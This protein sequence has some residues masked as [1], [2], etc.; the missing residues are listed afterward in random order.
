MTTQIV[1]WLNA[2]ANA[3][4]SVLLAP[5]AMMPGWL[6]ATLIA[7]ITGVLMLLAFKYTSNQSA[8]KRVRNDIKA[9][10]LAL[11]LFKD[12]IP[13]SLRS[14]G[15]IL[16]AA[17]RLLGLALIPMLVMLVPMCLLLGQLAAWYQARPLHID[18]PVVV[19]VRLGAMAD[20]AHRRYPAQ[21]IGPPSRR[22]SAPS[23]SPANKWCAG[24]F[25]AAKPD[26]IASP[27]RPQARCSKR[28][29]PS[30]MASCA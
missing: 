17:G 18:E 12:S 25:K 15:R 9:N 6:S 4:A 20:R 14:Q 21:C 19:T 23:A 29:W 1:I 13:V 30:A 10:L 16:C 22:R 27:L 26:T 3:L 24:T 8:I 5:I 2:L 7:A 11:S 28:N